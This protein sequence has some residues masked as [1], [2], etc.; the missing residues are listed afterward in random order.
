[1]KSL[2]L[3]RRVAAL[4][5]STAVLATMV[6]GLL[7]GSAQA[8]TP[9]SAGHKAQVSATKPAKPKVSV[10]TPKPSVAYYDE[11]CPVDIKFT[12]RVKVKLT[13][14]TVLAYRWLHG[15]G[16]KSKVRTIKL[17]GKGTKYVTV[18]QKLTFDQSVKGWE[19]L[20]VLG[21]RHVVS[22]KGYF[23]VA[24]G[25]KVWDEIGHPKVW[26]KAWAHPDD[27]VGP[28][29]P[30]NK[31]HFG[32][33]IKVDEPQ[34]VR[35]RWILNGEVVESDTIKVW[36]SRKVGFGFSPRSSHHGWAVL[37]VD[38][39]HDSAYAKVHYRVRCEDP[40]SVSV[41]EVSVSQP[42][43]ACK[44]PVSFHATITTNRKALV[45]YHWVI[46]GRATGFTHEW[47]DGSEP[48]SIPGDAAD[49]VKTQGSVKLVVTSPVSVE[50]TTLYNQACQPPAEAPKADGA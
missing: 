30:G 9:A 27:Y 19:A 48:V 4:G 14:K 41:S 1:M 37:D 49:A 39:R 7:A 16:S 50:R 17:S 20:E 46:N 43:G 11:A 12:A 24:C 21:P 8:A 33:V 35:Y 36:D 10:S 5:A 47:I 15:D 28:C 2:G 18:S 32:G 44:A 22:K 6:A 13:G 25:K 45:S 31:I 34:W 40:L 3:A 38:S 42:S 29:T 26:A 23:E